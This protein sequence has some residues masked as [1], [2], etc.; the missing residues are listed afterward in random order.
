MS[1]YKTHRTRVS[2]SS[3]YDEICMDCGARDFTMGEDE[4]S[5]R[6]CTKNTIEESRA[7]P[8]AERLKVTEGK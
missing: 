6:P 4:L 3:L 2:D 7:Q 8:K 1:H 5:A